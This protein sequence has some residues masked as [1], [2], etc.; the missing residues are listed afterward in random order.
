[1]IS[2]TDRKA[3]MQQRL[4]ALKSRLSEIST[5]LVVERSPDWEDLATE[6]ESDEVLEG[7]GN[8]G[9]LEIR[10]IEAALARIEAGDYGICA[11]CGQDIE[12][13]RLDVLPD[14]PFCRSCAP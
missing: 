6:R 7:M 10:R 13:E 5:E 2:T 8:A 11:T 9:L 3:Q 14:T 1:M 12:P 4:A